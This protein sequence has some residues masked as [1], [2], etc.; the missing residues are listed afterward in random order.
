MV[1][2]FSTTSQMT[3]WEFPKIQLTLWIPLV[4]KQ[5]NGKIPCSMSSPEKT[6]VLLWDVPFFRPTFS[7]KIT[8]P[9]S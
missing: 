5:N 4:I 1:D 9:I 2:D 7:R 3:G 8:K 6:S